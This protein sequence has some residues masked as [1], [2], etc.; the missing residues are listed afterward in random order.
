VLA[1]GSE[2]RTGITSGPMAALTIPAASLADLTLNDDY[3]F[4]VALVWKD[5]KG[6]RI[7]TRRHGMFAYVGEYVFDRVEASTDPAPAPPSADAE[8]DLTEPAPNTNDPIP[9][10][11]AQAYREFWH[12]VWEGPFT[13]DVRTRRI[14]LKYYYTLADNGSAGRLETM[15][16]VVKGE[17]DERMLQLKTGLAVS[18]DALSRLASSLE[19]GPSLDASQLDALRAPDFR[20]R[21]AQGA[22]T[23]LTLR[24]RAGE[25]AAV[26]VFPEVKMHDVVLKHADAVADDGQVTAFG[27]TVVRFPLMALAHVVGARTAR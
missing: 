9:L 1:R 13:D 12:K 18:S 19:P 16:K 22:L 10:S 7:G 14:E 27:E 6:E 24:G 2:K 23:R 4:C 5:K 8:L 26:W 20:A 3:L 11:D 21:F 17:N 25:R 15:Q